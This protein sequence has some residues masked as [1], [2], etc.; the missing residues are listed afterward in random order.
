MR[1]QTLLLLNKSK[2]TMASPAKRS[3]RV[4]PALA[5]AVTLAT[6]HSTEVNSQS[7]KKIAE[8]TRLVPELQKYR[9][10]TAESILTFSFNK[11]RVRI[12]SEE[13]SVPETCT[14][15]VY[16]M[17]RDC[18]VQ[19]NWAF[20]LAQK[21]ALKNEVPLHVCFCL[22]SEYLDISYRQFHFLLKGK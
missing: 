21:L 7:K 11:K 18:R 16:W 9:E 20:L 22:V 4:A 5:P 19:D 6:L 15:V 10:D 2:I 12:I 1:I 17:F 3:K 13:Q 14:G 8:L